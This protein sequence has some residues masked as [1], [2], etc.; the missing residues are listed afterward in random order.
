MWVLTQHGA[1]SVVAYDPDRDLADGPK[2]PAGTHLLVRAR[3]RGDLEALRQWIPDL[4]VHEDRKAD[5]PYR[6]V[7]SRAEWDGAMAAEAA[8]VDYTTDF[9]GRV[10]EVLGLDREALY[11]QV[12]A[13]LRGI[14]D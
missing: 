8:I 5:Y 2:P 12:W 13:I 4:L 10:G 1:Y 9:K 14:R 7:V 11:T 6:A 3:A